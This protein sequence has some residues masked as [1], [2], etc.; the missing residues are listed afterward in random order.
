MKNRF[1]VL[2]LPILF[3]ATPSKV[4]AQNNDTDGWLFDWTSP[5]PTDGIGGGIRGPR[6]PG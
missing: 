4:S 5:S 3:L 2:L 1:V 6:F